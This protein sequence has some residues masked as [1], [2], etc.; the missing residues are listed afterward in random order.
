MW[1][2]FEARKYKIMYHIYQVSSSNER[3]GLTMWADRPTDISRLK[4][5]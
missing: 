4:F 3:V 5:C 1:G 2:K